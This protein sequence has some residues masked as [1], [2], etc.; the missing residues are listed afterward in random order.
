MTESGGPVIV[1]G[2][3]IAGLVASIELERRG[4]SVI[5]LEAEAEVGGRVRSR[6]VDGFRIDRGFQVLFT[7]YPVLGQYLDLSA[8]DLRP[9]QPAARIA[10]PTGTSVIGDVLQD[11]SLLAETILSSHIPVADLWRLLRL[12]RYAT[13]LD[14]NNCFAPLHAGRSTRDF[15]ESR[16]FTATTIERFFTPFYGGILLD[17]SLESSAAVLLFTFAMLARGQTALPARGMG[18]IAAQLRGRLRFAEV[19]TGAR[20]TKVLVDS[21]RV[22]GVL[23]G[24]GT[25]I[26]G[27]DVLLATEAPTAAALAASAGNE[28]AHLPTQARG[29]TTIYF[30]SA[31]PVLPGR[32]LTLNATEHAVI[33]HAVTVTDIAP[34]YSADGRHLLAMTAVGSAAGLSDAALER[35]AVSDLIMMRRASLKATVSVVAIERVPYSQFSH[36]PGYAQSRPV[37]RTSLPGLWF[38]GEALHSSSLDGAARAGVISASAIT[39]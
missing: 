26:A 23:L 33:S 16:G 4:R 27:R 18:A 13:R 34:E 29:S 7:A 17:R 9:F 6:R 1:V 32:A 24:D 30:S 35:A 8:L 31:E 38:G 37:A 15:L 36:P 19:R 2:G 22:S 5:L 3:G 25:T 28:I 21:G 39:Q 10:L 12:R 11:S 14:D 20:V